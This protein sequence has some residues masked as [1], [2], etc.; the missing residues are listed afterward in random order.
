M[1][2]RKSIVDG[3]KMRQYLAEFVG[4]FLLVFFGTAS[5]SSAA[6]S[7]ALVGLG[8]VA[9]VWGC[10]VALSIYCVGHISGA[11]LNPAVTLAFAVWDSFPWSNVIGYVVAQFL[12]SLCAAGLNW[13]LYSTSV[14]RFEEANGIIR[15]A[16]GSE[17]SALIFG[18]YFPNPG[19]YTIPKGSTAAEIISIQSFISVGLAFTAE[20]VGT[21][22]LMFIILA[23][24]DPKN[25]SVSPKAVPALIGMTVATLISVLAPISQAG[26]NPARDFAPRIVAL[27]CGWGSKVALQDGFWVF[28]LGPIVGA[29]V[30]AALHFGLYK[31][32][33]ERSS[34][35]GV[36]REETESSAAAAEAGRV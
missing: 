2:K 35:V 33:F 32:D 12:G 36:A 26:F 13:G 25:S 1:E 23:L 18:E 30:G 17:K 29:Q 8:Q 6:I 21:A 10:G 9:T 11:H 31:A 20:L 5:V 22:L 4:T 15:G 28:I 16:P 34:K 14:A 7:G 24:I 3:T 27:A 19:T